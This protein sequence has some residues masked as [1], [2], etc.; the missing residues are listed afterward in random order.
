MKTFDKAAAD[1]RRSMWILGIFSLA[2]NLLLLTI[3]LYML[4]IYDR[5]LTSRSTDTLMFLSLVAAFSLLVLALIEVVRSVL[6]NR[7]ASRLDVGLSELALRTSIRAGAATGGSIQPLREVAA[8][9]QLLSSRLVFAPMDL[10]FASI[11][12]GLLYFIHPSLFWITLGG[13]GILAVIAIVNQ[14]AIARSSSSQSAA[15]SVAG[16]RADFFARCADSLIAMGMVRNVIQHWGMEHGRSLADGDHANTVNS[17]YAGLSKLVRLGLQIVIL[18][19]GAHLVL[20]GEMTAGMIFASSLLSG[21][22]LQPI[23]QMIGSWR[24]LT[25][26][27]SSWRKLRRILEQAD[28]REEY[29]TLPAPRGDLEVADV[30]VPNLIDPTRPPV[31]ARVSFRLPAGQ[32]VAILGA[33]GSGKSTLA[34]VIVGA[35]KPRNGH[36]RIDGHDIANWDPEALGRYIGYLA[37]DVELIP[38]TV[39]QNISRFAPDATD[40]GIVAAARLAHAE[41]LV[42][43]LPKGYDTPIGPGGVQ[44]SGGEKQ[45]IGLARAFYGEPKLLVLDEPNSSLDRNGEMALMRA[46]MEAKKQGITVIVITQRE[47]VVGIVDRILRMKD[48]TITDYDER[49]KVIAKFRADAAKAHQ[50]DPRQQG[51]PGNGQASPGATANMSVGYGSTIALTE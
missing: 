10:P 21:R 13:A 19:Y 17:W 48:G 41:D 26:G 30:V 32:S 29:T 39:A 27:L 38:G 37:Q 3:P 7:A 1:F 42:Q 35:F 33:S 6:A 12:I 34:R 43:K 24:Q 23:D 28:V 18:G 14:W 44:I 36:V 31:L 16:N 11:F 9:R 25:A 22:G 47:M 40:A 50:Q 5:V 46:L 49:E 8:V 51:Q 4:Q 15:A 2:A 45:R 20:K